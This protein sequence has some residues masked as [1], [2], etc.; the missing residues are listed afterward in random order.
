M[1]Q[2]EFAMAKREGGCLCGAVRYVLDSEPTMTAVC[3][4]THCQ[5]QS[6]G[7]FST[8]LVVPEADY[9]QIGETKVFRDRGDSG[10]PVDRHFCPA[11]GSPIVSKVAIMP[12][13][14]MVKAGSL[15]DMSGLAPAVEVYTDHAVAWVSPIA[16]AR[17]FAQ[18]AG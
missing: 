1:A 4:C 10:Q 11:C 8:N 15:D 18:G 5:K 9:H 7:V 6:G 2:G 3:H 13:L 14:T 12:G 17:R 16:G